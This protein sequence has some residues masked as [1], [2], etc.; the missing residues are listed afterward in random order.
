MKKIVLALAAATFVVGGAYAQ[1]GD[2][3]PSDVDKGASSAPGDSKTNPP[4]TTGAMNN[5]TGATATSPQDAQAQ[6]SGQST[7]VEGGGSTGASTK[8][9]NK[10]SPENQTGK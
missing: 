9:P 4:K 2:V 7:A 10:S 3:K 1:S 8:D 5:V 6:Q